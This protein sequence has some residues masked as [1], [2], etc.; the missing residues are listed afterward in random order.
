[1]VATILRAMES[2]AQP[3]GIATDSALSMAALVVLGGTRVVFGSIVSHAT[4][5]DTFGFLGLLIGLTMLGSFVLPAGLSSAISRFIPFNRG[6]GDPAAARGLYR[7]L[8]RAS[9]VAAV[10]LSVA[11]FAIARLA[12]D[13]PI[14]QSVEAA[15]LMLTYALYT[16]YKAGL[17]GFA[18]VGSYVRLEILSSAIVLG[19]T[20]AVVL[21]GS[22]LFLA[23]FVVGYG[24]FAAAAAYLL[25]ADTK[26]PATTPDRGLRWEVAGYVALA[27]LG[28]L[29]AA[30]FLQGTQV[31][32]ASFAPPG[33]LASFAAAVTLV[34]PV[35][36]LPRALALAMFPAMARAHGAGDSQAI[37]R[38]AD[39][40]TRALVALLTPAFVAAIL[41]A[42][43][44]LRTF[45]G[46]AYVVGAPVLQLILFGAFLS[47]IQVGSVNALSSAG[48]RH[49]R[50]PVGWAVTGALCGLAFVAVAGPTLGSLG[51]AGGYVVGTLLASVGPMAEV[52]RRDQM[53]W[54]GILIRATIC[55]VL[56]I[57]VGLGLPASDGSLPARMM[58]VAGAA[59]AA[60]LSGAILF[61]DIRAVVVAARGGI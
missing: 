47:V 57:G 35:Q 29:A 31:L 17:Y 28:T 39:L 38:Q 20:V 42:P 45:G 4:D 16:T 44:I 6:R 14:G 5:R 58:L 37:R 24:A 55:L 50:I 61:R 40:S 27:C 19:L 34:A 25:R 1:M 32:A 30:G 2:R 26:G 10:L 33:E 36:F 13:R 46:D 56:A 21:T 52:W 51:I 43:E 11:V 59:I 22:T 60:G 15:L 23:P 48:G 54:S 3:S 53:G 9:L 18:R 7:Q 8:F 12:L 41:L 49:V